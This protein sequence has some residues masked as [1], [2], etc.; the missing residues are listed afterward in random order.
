MV[1][2]PA[3]V[4]PGAFEFVGRQAT[5]REKL[6]WAPPNSRRRQKLEAELARVVLEELQRE[7]KRPRGAESAQPRE[8]WWQR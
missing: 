4:S 7:T 8:Q 3:N 1:T 5:L 2:R 6:R